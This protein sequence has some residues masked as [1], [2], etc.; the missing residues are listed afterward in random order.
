MEQSKPDELVRYIYHQFCQLW[1]FQVPFQAPKLV[2]LYNK[3]P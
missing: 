2:V 1:K 3:K